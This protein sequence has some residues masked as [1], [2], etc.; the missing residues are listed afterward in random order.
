MFWTRKQHNFNPF[1]KLNQSKVTVVE[2]L[3][4]KKLDDEW[5][6][7][8]E[9]IRVKTPEDIANDVIQFAGKDYSEKELIF[10]SRVFYYYWE[11]KGIKTS[12]LPVDIKLKIDKA[13]SL[14][15]D[16]LRK[17]IDEIRQKEIQED[18]DKLPSYVAACLEWAQ[19]KR[20]KKMTKS[21]IESF[22]ADK[23]IKIH[24]ETKNK[25][26]YEVNLNF[27]NRSSM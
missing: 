18:N 14:V 9:E 20:L 27:E 4:Q 3:V 13:Q 6:T 22:L 10:P 21:A 8:L 23:N 17:R 15:S 26:Y 7:S 11:S 19:T 24:A 5:E 16:R 12:Y 2:E 1:D 25:L